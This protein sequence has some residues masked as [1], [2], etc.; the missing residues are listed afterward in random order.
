MAPNSQNKKQWNPPRAVDAG[1][2]LCGHS[3]LHGPE[4]KSARKDAE[5]QRLHREKQKPYSI[6]IHCACHL[7]ESF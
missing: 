3:S 2:E 1:F 5:T 6:N 4:G 7:E